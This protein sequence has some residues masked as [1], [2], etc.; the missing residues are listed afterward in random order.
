MRE[1]NNSN[2]NFI[3][4][5]LTVKHGRKHPPQPMKEEQHPCGTQKE[6]GLTSITTSKTQIGLG[7]NL[8]S[9]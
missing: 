4:C 1:Y 3:G 8:I 5:L 7:L 6:Q 9:A 2:K